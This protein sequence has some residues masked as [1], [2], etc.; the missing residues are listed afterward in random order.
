MTLHEIAFGLLK[1]DKTKKKK[2]RKT[3]LYEENR[4]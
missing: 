2:N 4:T 1:K 3:I